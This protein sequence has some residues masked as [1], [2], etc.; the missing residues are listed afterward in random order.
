MPHRV[1]D[2]ARGYLSL[3]EREQQALAEPNRQQS[4]GFETPPAEPD[5]CGGR[6]ESLDA[7]S[8]SPREALELLYELVKLARD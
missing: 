1:I 4:L 6:L 3:L 7:D 8:L 5:G 2:D